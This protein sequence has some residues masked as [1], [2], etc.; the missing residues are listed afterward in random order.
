MNIGDLVRYEW[1]EGVEYGVIL[2]EPRIV[3]GDHFN[4]LNTD[5]YPVVDVKLDSGVVETLVIF[6]LEVVNERTD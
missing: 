2:S 3:M 4:L 1:E 6:D 5:P